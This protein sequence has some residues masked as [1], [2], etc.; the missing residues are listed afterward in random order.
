MRD[1]SNGTSGEDNIIMVTCF[2]PKKMTYAQMYAIIDKHLKEN[3]EI[4]NQPLPTII[5]NKVASLCPREH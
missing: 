1:E 4:R 2:L 5:F 3:P